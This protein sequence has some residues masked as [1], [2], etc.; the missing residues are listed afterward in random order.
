M[1]S[2]RSFVAAAIAVLIGSLRVAPA[3]A[4]V[5]PTKI[6]NSGIYGTHAHS[7]PRGQTP[8]LLAVD[9]GAYWEAYDRHIYKGLFSKCRS[10]ES[11]PD[12]RDC[13]LLP[14]YSF[15]GLIN[16]NGFKTLKL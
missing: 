13:P 7:W 2:R 10:L 14:E 6:H 12:F 4:S 11:M 3:L 5:R 8:A 1:A 16:P 9:E 15:S